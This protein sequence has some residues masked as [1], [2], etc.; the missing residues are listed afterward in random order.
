MTPFDPAAADVIGSDGRAPRYGDPDGLALLSLV[1]NQHPLRRTGPVRRGSAA[2]V[3]SLLVVLALVAGCTQSGSRPEPGPSPAP[4]SSADRKTSADNRPNIVFVLTDDLSWNM[5]KYL[6]Q[7]RKLQRKGTTFTNFF[8]VNSLCCPSRSAIFTGEY[9]HDNGVFRNVGSD[10]GYSGYVNHG[11]E[12]KSFAVALQQA[13]YH[14]GFMGKYLNGYRPRKNP[15][16][17]G[18]DDW[19]VAGNGYHEYNYVL[20]ENGTKRRYGSKPS[21]YL[22]DVLAGKAA[23][24]IDRAAAG[25]RP[26]MLEVASFAPHMP[27]TPAPRDRKAYP[28]IKGPRTPAYNRLPSNA[29]AWLKTVP[30]LKDKEKKSGDQAFAK[31][32]RS[33]LAVDDMVGR[34]RRQLK[35]EGLAKN[36]YFVFSSDNGFHIGEHRLRRGKQTAYDTDIR[37]PLVVSGPKVP[38]G[39]TMSAMTSTIDLCP[40]FAAIGGA[41]LKGRPD[42]VSMLGLWH[43][44]HPAN[45]Q[46]AVL[47][48]HRTDGTMSPK[49][50]DYQTSKHGDPPTY[51]AIRTRTA[52]YAEYDGGQREYYDL[53]KDPNELHNLAGKLPARKLDPIKK[54]LA[55]LRSCHGAAQC[56]RAAQLR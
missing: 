51:Q 45:W 1:V 31:R 8:T 35:A 24:F 15:A 33:A 3:V 49:D 16:A 53:R 48:E 40:T 29:P 26:F 17:P 6:P 52:M 13:G 43:G 27:A 4:S 12:Q 25:Q 11:N 39:R 28:K 21:D 22:T 18:W 20:N 54:A 38:A 9:P 37:V 44:K 41:K 14:T 50:P 46:Q 55:A 7:V 23:D 56:Q 32:V 42:G 19:V 30:P 10:G 36:T 2:V 47:V 5:M 34:L